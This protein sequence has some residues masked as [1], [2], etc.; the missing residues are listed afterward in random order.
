MSLS[1]H[2]ARHNS[3]CVLSELGDAIR[4]NQPGNN[5]CDLSLIIVEDPSRVAPSQVIEIANER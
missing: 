1:E 5:V 2:L 3:S 4:F